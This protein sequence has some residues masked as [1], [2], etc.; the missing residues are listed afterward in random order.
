MFKNIND[1]CGL[2]NASSVEV[3]RVN[4]LNLRCTSES[5]KIVAINCLQQFKNMQA[6][7]VPA[8]VRIYWRAV[9]EVTL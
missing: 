4:A 5:N 9:C 8:G 3:I 2:Y 1:L 7:T 6:R